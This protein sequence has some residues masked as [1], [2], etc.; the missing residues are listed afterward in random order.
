MANHIWHTYG[1]YGYIYI[2]I[3]LYPQTRFCIGSI[4]SI[5]LG[6][7]GSAT[8]KT[9]IV[10]IHLGGHQESWIYMLH[11]LDISELFPFTILQISLRDRMQ[12]KII[13]ILH[14]IRSRSVE[15]LGH[16][17]GHTRFKMSVQFAAEQ[18]SLQDTSTCAHSG[19][20]IYVYI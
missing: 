20:Q 17:P 11:E 9:V 4:G 6:H 13:Y 3:K 1:S 18:R 14:F 12:Q 7:L 15:Y 5:F 19:S 2:Y 16:E 8:L 10:P